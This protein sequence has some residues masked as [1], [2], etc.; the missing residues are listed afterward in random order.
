MSDTFTEVSSEGFFSRLSGAIGG[1]LVGI[2]FTL[3]SFPLLW[4]NEGRAVTTAQ[5]LAEG[6][7]SV[8]EVAPEK[9]DPGQD[10]KLV[11]L[12]GQADTEETIEDPDFKVSQ[13]ALKIVRMVEMYQWVE[14]KSEK[15]EKKVG[16]G[17]K[18][19]TTYSYDKQWDSDLNNSSNFKQPDG[20][21]NPGQMAFQRRTS[22]PS[23]IRVGARTLG[24]SQ[25]SSI[26]G[27]EMLAMGEE[28]Q[29][30]LPRAL[31]TRTR[32]AEGMFYIGAQGPPE[33]QSPAVGDLRVS[34]KIIRPQPVSIIAA[35]AGN[36]FAAYQTQAGDKL[37]MLSMGTRSAD[38]MFSDAETANTI[39]TWVLRF[40]G[41]F[42]MF[43]GIVMVFRPFEVMA[44]II[45]FVGNLVGTGIAFFAA[46]LASFLSLITIAIAWIRFRPVVGLLLLAGAVGL[47]VM[48]KK[49]SAKPAGAAPPPVPPAGPPPIPEA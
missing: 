47:M 4:W 22:V 44:D 11:H 1:V 7:G 41:W 40:V 32:S 45:P 25:V 17:T 36:S 15:T 10:G 35:Q 43:L 19:T 6:R 20:H 24:D 30:K 34:F 14:K 13:K 37:D 26:S 12:S 33:P 16:G 2:L 5:S 48:G 9:V 21:Q 29:R 18:K 3:A 8:V 46:V 23:V 39:M 28:D 27:G 49:M 42:L 31:R 38:E